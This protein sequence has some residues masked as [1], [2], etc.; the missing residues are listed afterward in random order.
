LLAVT[1]EHWLGAITPFGGAS[2]LAGWGWL[3]F[4]TKLDGA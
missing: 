4:T 3:I 2:F 1:N